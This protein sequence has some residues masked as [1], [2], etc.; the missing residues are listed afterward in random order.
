M[1][2]SKIGQIY[3]VSH[4]RLLAILFEM[5]KSRISTLIFN[6][7][8]KLSFP[9]ISILEPKAMPCLSK[10]FKN[11]DEVSLTPTQIPAWFSCN[12]EIAFR[13]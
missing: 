2:H 13:F 10:Y 9:M 8:S 1:I 11:S 4:K 12:S 6:D 3:Y 7:K 5:D